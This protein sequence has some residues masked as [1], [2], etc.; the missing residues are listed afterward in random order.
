V[1]AMTSIA[2]VDHRAWAIVER[3]LEVLANSRAKANTE[4]VAQ[5]EEM[6]KQTSRTQSNQ[7]G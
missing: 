6:T 4:G 3:P 1:T 7:R 2:N 5:T